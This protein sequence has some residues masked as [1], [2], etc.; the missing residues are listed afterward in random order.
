MKIGFFTTTYYPTPDGVSH[1]LRDVKHELENRGHEVHVFSYNGDRHEKNVHVPFTVPFLPYPQ[2]RVPLNPIPFYMFRIAK[3]TGFDIIHIHD[4]F[5]GSIGYRLSR[6]MDIPVIATFHTDFVRMRE[7]LKMPFKDILI[8]L[9]WRYNSY[10]LKRCNVVLAPSIKTADYLKG[11]GIENS[12]ELPLF[13][14][15]GKFKSDR[16]SLD[17]F[18]IQYIGR[19]T[20][21]KGVFRI[22]D[23][24]EAM[25]STTRVKFVIS[26]AGP[27]EESLSREIRNRDLTDRVSVTGYVDEKKKIELLGNANLF[28]YPSETDTF[29]ISVLE[30]LSTGIPTII[31][32]GF[33]L[34][35][36]NGPG[37]SGLIEM[38]FSDP[39]PVSRKIMELH[40]D[41]EKLR[42][43][44]D[45]ARAFVTGNFS[46]EGHCDR[47]VE[48]YKSHI[49]SSGAQK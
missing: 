4:P 34:T 12:E 31:P 39:G 42:L 36:Y 16:K 44:N 18:I 25:G 49:K 6:S 38:D 27:E 10:L 46:M 26:G 29:G 28:I 17:P 2:Y 14:D 30:A 13:V 11:H 41:E 37:D 22:L 19:I 20:R 47:L 35:H 32:K 1:Y 24:A 15:T 7:A 21:D 33:P 45:A 43:L 48:I 3:R 5:M 23:V 9:S 40:D 8:R